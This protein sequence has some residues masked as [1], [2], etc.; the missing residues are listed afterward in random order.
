MKFRKKPTI[1][2]AEIFEGKDPD[3]KGI[4]FK[5]LMTDKSW[6]IYNALHKSWIQIKVGDYFRTDI[7]GD[8]YPIDAEYMKENYDEIV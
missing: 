2:E 5:Y 4:S 8:N 3:I 1:I 7:V 6:K